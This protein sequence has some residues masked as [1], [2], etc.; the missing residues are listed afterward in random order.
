MIVCI[1]Q[2]SL[3]GAE[4]SKSEKEQK[5]PALPRNWSNSIGGKIPNPLD[6]LES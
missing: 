5:M 3:K 2:T 1:V 6:C 4:C